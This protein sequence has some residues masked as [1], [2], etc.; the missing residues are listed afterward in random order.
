MNIYI[1]TTERKE[2]SAVHNRVSLNTRQQSARGVS[3][4]QSKLIRPTSQ[5][6]KGQCF[7]QFHTLCSQIYKRM[8]LVAE[9][10]QFLLRLAP[11]D[12]LCVRTRLCPP[13]VQA[14]L[15]RLLLSISQRQVSMICGETGG[16]LGWPPENKL[17]TIRASARRLEVAYS[18]HR[19]STCDRNSESRA[20]SG[21][22]R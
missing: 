4:A 22:C 3:S 14:Q 10:T 7:N 9:C 17:R 15:V 20:V 18:H 2:G 6:H 1:T 19:S 16:K 8:V 11:A 21:S 13:E 5:K 12:R